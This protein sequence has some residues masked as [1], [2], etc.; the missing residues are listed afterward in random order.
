MAYWHGRYRILSRREVNDMQELG[1]HELDEERIELLPSRETLY[2]HNNWANVWASNS[3]MALNAASYFS[4]A[5][6]AAYQSVYVH[7]G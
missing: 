7:Q 5:E 2:I 1:I 6:S 3:S 4:H